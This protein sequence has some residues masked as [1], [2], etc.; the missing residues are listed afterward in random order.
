VI[1]S[2]Q[3][4]SILIGTLES[5]LAQCIGGD[6]VIVVDQTLR[7]EPETE[8]RLSEL[9]RKGE[10]RWVRKSKPSICEAMNLGAALAR[11][12]LLVFLDDDARPFEDFLE[13][14][15]RLFALAD[16]PL[17]ACGQILQPWDEG[18]SDA[19][20]GD[21][22]NFNFASRH[23]GE[24][25]GVMAG[26][27]AVRRSVFLE[28]GG[29]DEAFRGGAY[30]CDAE[31]GFRLLARTGRRV[32]FEPSAAVRHLHAEG[33]TR[34]HGHK[35]TWAAIESAIG[36]YYFGFRCLSPRQS[37]GHALRR[38]GRAPFN[39]N[40]AS[41]PWLVVSV[42]A[43]EGVAWVRAFARARRGG[44]FIRLVDAYDDVLGPG[45]T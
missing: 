6:E 20:G 15:R 37:F 36:D 11:G 31:V 43:R 42:L 38:L 3:R 26:N 19:P 29:M 23:P 44:R 2:Y 10:V 22:G 40:T 41:R 18:P 27:F 7:H 25:V 39:R 8:R 4:E 30:R 28:V 9:N 5:I 14:Y 1:P 34:A 24:L 13:A 32:R 16:A 21:A 45:S 12:E 33:G 17:A 35:D